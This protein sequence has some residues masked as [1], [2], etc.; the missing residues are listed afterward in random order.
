MDTGN[1]FK[2]LQPQF[3][4]LEN[5]KHASFVFLPQLLLKKK[6]ED[7]PFTNC[8]TPSLEDNIYSYWTLI[9]TKAAFSNVVTQTIL[10]KT[11]PKKLIG[12]AIDPN[13]VHSS[14]PSSTSRSVH[15]KP[16]PPLHQA[17][18]SPATIMRFP[19]SVR[20]G[21]SP[22]LKT[23]LQVQ[24]SLSWQPNYNLLCILHVSRVH[25]IK[26]SAM[27]TEA[28]IIFILKAFFL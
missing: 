13:T 21:F 24:A 8:M 5:E 7:K 23:A 22:K 19:S 9:I 1:S 25:W 4:H 12:E 15:W 6:K 26:H 11:P 3:P 20:C 18:D 2:P 14:R 27:N 10:K 17:P 16:Q 28:D